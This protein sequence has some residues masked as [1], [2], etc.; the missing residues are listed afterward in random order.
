V[1]GDERGHGNRAAERGIKVNFLA[2]ARG[3]E[4]VATG[5][6]VKAGKNLTICQGNV[7]CVDEG[8]EV[9]VAVMLA[10]MMILKG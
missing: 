3:R 1:R 4:F 9:Q 2:P 7:E 10:T 6:V 5:Q 8:A